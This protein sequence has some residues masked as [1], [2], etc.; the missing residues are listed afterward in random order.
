LSTSPQLRATPHLE[1]LSLHGWGRPRICVILTCQF[2]WQTGYDALKKK[3]LC[4]A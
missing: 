2:G 3:S 1:F 4:H